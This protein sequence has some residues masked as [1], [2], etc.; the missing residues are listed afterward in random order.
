[1]DKSSTRLLQKLSVVVPARNEDGCIASTVQHLHLELE[2]KKVPHEI[3]VVDD[4]STDR[5][6][7]NNL[8]CEVSTLKSVLDNV[9]VEDILCTP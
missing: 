3:I 5:T 9:R 2:L 1:M 6:F 8:A 4:G 7:P